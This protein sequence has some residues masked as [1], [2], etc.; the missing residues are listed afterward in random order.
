MKTIAFIPVRGGSVSIPLKNI[1]LLNGRPLVYY[2]LDAAC[3]CDFIDTVVVAT[4]HEGIKQIVERYS[5]NKIK[6]VG[7]SPEVS[8]AIAPTID[9]M[10]EFAENNKFE[11]II[12]MQATSPLTTSQDII[13]AYKVYQEGY[14]S[15]LSVVRQHRFIWDEKT[16]TSNYDLY[17]RPRRQD[18]DG[19]LIENGA[20]YIISYEKLIKLKA[21]VIGNVGLYEMSAETYI[22]LDCE[23]DWIMMENFMRK[24]QK[25]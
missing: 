19:I 1:K 17:N 7:R 20:F 8:T 4:D 2:T 5:S 14:D 12:L 21:P 11:T 25:K 15:V 13:N 23:L 16:R 24:V 9:V 6:V 18:W 3:E 10:L 22:E